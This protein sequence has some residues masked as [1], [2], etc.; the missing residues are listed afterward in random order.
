MFARSIEILLAS[1]KP[2]AVPAANTPKRAAW[3]KCGARAR[4]R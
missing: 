2:L 4:S 1:I 3:I